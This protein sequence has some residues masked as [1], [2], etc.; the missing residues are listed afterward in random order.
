M[1]YSVTIA[2]LFL[3]LPLGILIFYSLLYQVFFNYNVCNPILTLIGAMLVLINVTQYCF[4]NIK[5]S[6]KHYSKDIK[7]EI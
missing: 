2:H 6:I 5:S 3:R 4:E 1:R 7:N